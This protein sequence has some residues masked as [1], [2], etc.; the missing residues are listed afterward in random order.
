MEPDLTVI[1][2][3]EAV[4]KKQFVDIDLIDT[5]EVFSLRYDVDGPSVLRFIG[6]R[7]PWTRGCAAKNP[8]DL[9]IVFLNKLPQKS[10]FK[11][12]PEFKG[13][14]YT[15]AACVPVDPQVAETMKDQLAS[16]HRTEDPGVLRQ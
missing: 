12:D 4:E 3:I 6:N 14:T 9:Y 2:T 15:A 16:G 7:A 8:D 13:I 1:G 11:R 10:L 5:I